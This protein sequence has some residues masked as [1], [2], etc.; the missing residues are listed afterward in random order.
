MK[1]LQVAPITYEMARQLVKPLKVRNANE[2]ANA[3][4]QAEFKK[5][6]L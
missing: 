3:L 1:N 2:V 5:R 4:I 6:G